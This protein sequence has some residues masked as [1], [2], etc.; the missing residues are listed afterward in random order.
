MGSED[1]KNCKNKDC[2]NCRYSSLNC[3]IENGTFTFWKREDN[4]QMYVQTD[5]IKPYFDV[6]V[7]QE[8]SSRSQIRKICK[9][10]GYV[11]GDD[12]DLT[13]DAKRNKEHIRK[14]FVQGLHN[15]IMRNIG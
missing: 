15:E 13:S 7:G 5:S 9:Q 1:N 4:A 8:V 3:D 6:A 12:C 10:K 14:A 2:V 11:Y